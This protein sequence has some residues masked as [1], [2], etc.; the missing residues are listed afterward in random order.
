LGA[1]LRFTHAR[2]SLQYR[3]KGRKEEMEIHVDLKG[4]KWP[5][6]TSRSTKAFTNEIN[7]GVE[8]RKR[9]AIELQAA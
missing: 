7:T 3:K 5:K 1:G 8:N 9:E 2:G 6:G 4:R